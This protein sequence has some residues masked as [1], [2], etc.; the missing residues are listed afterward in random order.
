MKVHVRCC[1]THLK[2]RS[3]EKKSVASVEELQFAN[4]A[5]IH[6]LDAMTFVDDEAFPR[7]MTD[8]LRK[9]RDET[10]VG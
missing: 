2:R 3:G 4:E 6:V 8:E 10:S 5:T 1:R 9:E 7:V